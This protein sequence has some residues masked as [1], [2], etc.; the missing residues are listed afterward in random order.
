MT[1]ESDDAAGPG[2]IA[3]SAHTRR[4]KLARDRLLELGPGPGAEMD[5]PVDE[6]PGRA[7][8]PAPQ[9]AEVVVVDPSGVDALPKL[10]VEALE[11]EAYGLCVAP[12]LGVAQLELVGEE[13]IVHL[14][15]PALGAGGLGRLGRGAGAGME[16]HHRHV[17]EGE[18]KAIAVATE[19]LAHDRIG[20]AAVRALE[21]AVL[22]QRHERSRPAAQVIAR[23]IN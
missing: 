1:L 23:G 18:A 16:V 20:V 9:A 3:A 14:P 13:A 12:K 22:D 2:A 10:A 4:P 21:V 15:E 7:R 8:D 17:A 5:S 11:V 19:Q 6:E